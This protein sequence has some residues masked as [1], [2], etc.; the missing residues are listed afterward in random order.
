VTTTFETYT[1]RFVDL[2]KPDPDTIAIDD[3]AWN[4]SRLPRFTGSTRSDLVYSVA[5]HSVLV[6]N[7]VRQVNAD[8]T[9]SL[10]L[11]ALLHDAHEAYMGDLS[12]PM[13]NLLDMKMPVARLKSRLQNAI[14]RGLLGDI[15]WDGKKFVQYI[16][17]VVK[18]ADLWARTYEAY[19][20]MHS[21]GGNWVSSSVLA[22]EHILRNVLVWSPAK[23]RESFLNHYLE[24]IT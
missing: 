19:H 3:I 13:C 6:L 24:L 16:G 11:T 1:G 9:R 17:P 15:E 21:K 14:Y 5:Q 2:S 22:E 23:A 7:R 18:E 10:L 8:V 12:S 20:L 4:L